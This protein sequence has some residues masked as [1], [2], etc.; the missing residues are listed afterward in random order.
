MSTLLTYLSLRGV[1]VAKSQTSL[2][3]RSV[4]SSTRAIQ[5]LY[6]QSQRSIRARVTVCR[7]MTQTHEPTTQQVR[8]TTQSHRDRALPRQPPVHR[9]RP[10]TPWQ[11]RQVVSNKKGGKSLTRLTRKM[12]SA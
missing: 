7:L 1:A 12:T 3:I 2:Y 11:G 8:L 4:T 10:P 9:R 6:S 5:L